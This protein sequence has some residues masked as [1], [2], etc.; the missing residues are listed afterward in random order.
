MSSPRIALDHNV[1][2]KCNDQTLVKLCFTLKKYMSI[3]GQKCM[4]LNSV[5]G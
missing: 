4:K 1:H 5:D 3:I 2:T